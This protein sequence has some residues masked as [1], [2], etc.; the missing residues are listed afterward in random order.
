VVR[1]L[2]AAGLDD[3]G[4]ETWHREFERFAPESHQD[5]LEAPGLP[6]PEVARIRACSLAHPSSAR[7][8]RNP[9]WRAADASVSS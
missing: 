3:A 4:M 2:R 7:A 8:G 6:P 9:S 5:F 1:L